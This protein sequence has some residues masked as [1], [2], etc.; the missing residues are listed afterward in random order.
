MLEKLY[1]EIAIQ[2]DIENELKSE[3]DPFDIYKNLN[4]ENFYLLIP[5]DYINNFNKQFD[6]EEIKKASKAYPDHKFEE[7]LTGFNIA[8]ES[9]IMQQISY[10]D[11]K[12]QIKLTPRA[13]INL[14]DIKT[15]FIQGTEDVFGLWNIYLMGHGQYAE[16]IEDLLSLLSTKIAKEI[17]TSGAIIAGLNITNFRTLI[18]F[19]SKNINMNFLCYVSCFA[20]GYNRILPYINTL[21]N[22][23]GNILGGV[24][25]PNFTIVSSSTID[26]P[27]TINLA[28]SNF[29]DFFNFLNKYTRK[30]IITPTKFSDLQLRD[31]LNPITPKVEISEEKYDSRISQIPLVM[32]PE[33][34]F[35]RAIALD[36]SI[37]IISGV[38][39]KKMILER[40][41]IEMKNKI[42]VLIYP[43]NVLALT[44]YNEDLNTKLPVIISMIP[45]ISLNKIFSLVTNMTFSQFIQSII[46]L[47]I[48]FERFFFI[49]TL[50]VLNDKNTT[51][52]EP[53][54]Q[55]IYLHSVLIHIN[56]RIDKN[57]PNIVDI[58]FTDKDGIMYTNTYEKGNFI[59]TPSTKLPIQ[60]IKIFSDEFID[61]VY[62][63]FLLSKKAPRLVMHEQFLSKFGFNILIKLLSPEDSKTLK[64]LTKESAQ[65]EIKS[66]KDFL[67]K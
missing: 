19:F 42:A 25:N 35:F 13:E 52:V 23:K 22:E 12:K 56:K 58:I 50:S 20:G 39:A 49:E 43:N 54:G 47:E 10:E 11:M 31:I 7:F 33:T 17:D 55:P 4:N 24:Q 9:K 27:V 21:I 57:S 32:F 36:D 6:I 45:G 18:Q 53:E 51:G 28:Q 5:K 48:A 44:L 26:A 62:N 15:I 64:E 1:K 34:G 60:K 63:Y 38:L 3:Y 30:D 46:G 41:I 8:P 37:G 59:K 29:V 61:S 67:N 65:E 40:G 16:K 14:N 66:S 2:M